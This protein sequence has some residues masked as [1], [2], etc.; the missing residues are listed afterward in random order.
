MA[1]F[2]L[3]DVISASFA[4]ISVINGSNKAAIVANAG[5][6]A[7]G[8]LNI[9]LTVLIA[10]RIWWDSRKISRHMG[11]WST[12]GTNTIISIVL[13]SGILYAVPLM[14]YVITNYFPDLRVDLNVV[15]I[16]VAGIAPTLIVARANAR[17]RE[18][19]YDHSREEEESGH[20]G[21]NIIILTQ[22]DGEIKTPVQTIQ[23]TLLTK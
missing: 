23:S 18:S 14:A 16:Q 9:T 7:N 4:L 3:I 17:R 20:V 1:G 22:I 12:K 6:G 2:V 19:D 15:L 13:E 11:K 5:L 8:I 21:D 10:A